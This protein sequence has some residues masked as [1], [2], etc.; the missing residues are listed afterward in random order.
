MVWDLKFARALWWTSQYIR[1]KWYTERN[2]CIFYLITHWPPKLFV[3]HIESFVHFVAYSTACGSRIIFSRLC[4][5]KFF[6]FFDQSYFLIRNVRSR[7]VGSNQKL[8]RIIV[9][10]HVYGISQKPARI[11]SPSLQVLLQCSLI[12][13]GIPRQTRWISQVMEKYSSNVLDWI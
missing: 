1:Q 5:Y 11:I 8:S 4:G 3:N 13:V 9:S 12:P 6:F 7:N 10:S 2:F